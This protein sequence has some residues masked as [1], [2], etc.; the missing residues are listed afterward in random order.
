[1]PLDP[2]TGSLLVAG[3]HAA[4]QGINVAA[5][6]RMN[7]KTRKWSEKMYAQQRADA[8]SDWNMQNIYNSPEAQMQRIKAAGLNPHLIY[9]Q[10]TVGN[11]GNVRSADAPSW[12]P[13]APQVDLGSAA[14][15]AVGTYFDIQLRGQNLEN[16]KTQNEL[17]QREKTLKELEGLTKMLN[18]DL[19][20]V[21]LDR[22]K[23]KY[24]IESKLQELDIPVATAQEN[25]NRLRNENRIA[26]NRDEREAAQNASN[27]REAAER[28]LT[29]RL[30]RVKTA[31]EIKN[32][33][34]QL[35]LLNQEEIIKQFDVNLVRGDYNK[36]QRPGDNMLFRKLG[37][38]LDFLEQKVGGAMKALSE[39]WLFK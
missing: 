37:Q 21:N 15:G 4:G 28:I 31:A 26:T 11:A 7:K 13:E 3:I 5:Q 17:M 33:E 36:G 25:L 34:Q 38:L 14:Q 16:M 12:H 8:L 30:G 6:G 24:S 35:K 2:V 32:I 27:L 39:S 19:G 22:T 18:L 1:M 10:G 9:G 23:L 29:M 20:K